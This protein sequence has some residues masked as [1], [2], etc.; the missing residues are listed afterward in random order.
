MGNRVATTSTMTPLVYDYEVVPNVI[1]KLDITLTQLKPLDQ[2]AIL[3]WQS[4]T[5]IRH[6]YTQE[7]ITLIGTP[8]IK[9]DRIKSPQYSTQTKYAKTNLETNKIEPLEQTL[10]RFAP[11]RIIKPYLLELDCAL[12]PPSTKI[13]ET[14]LSSSM[15]AIKTERTATFTILFCIQDRN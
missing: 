1:Y 13:L 5:Q 2:D 3:K 10:Q 9:C 4:D 6:D 14:Y 7:I 8:G 12:F 11:H 15:E